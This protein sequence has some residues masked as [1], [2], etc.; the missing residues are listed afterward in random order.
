MKEELL[1][2]IWKYKLFYTSDL[3]TVS[4]KPIYL[5]SVGTHN[6]NSGPD[7]LNAKLRIDDQLWAGNVE[8][9]I[10]ASDWY[11]H[12]HENDEQF[13]ALILHVVWEN[14][15]AVFDKSNN[16]L[17]TLELKNCVSKELLKSY[18]Q[19]FSKSNKFINCERNFNNIDTF[20]IA[21]WKERLY[22][23]RLERKA[24]EI[25]SLLKATEYNWEQVLF[26]LLAKNFG[27]K[28]NS[29]AFFRMSTSVDFN[30][31][32]RE[33]QN[34]K[35]MES[36]L[37]GQLGLLDEDCDVT[38]YQQLRKEYKYQKKKYKLEKQPIP[39]L[40]F[41]LRPTNFPTIRIMQLANLLVQK[42][43]LFTEVMQFN[44]LK[45][46]YKYFE[47]ATSEF[48]KTHYTFETVSKISS[49]KL[50]KSFIDI[51][52]LNSIIPLKYVYLKHKGKFDLD[53]F[54]KLIRQL[55]PEKN[56][57]IENYKKLG[58]SVDNAFESQALLE[59]KKNY[60]TPQKCLQCAIGLNLLRS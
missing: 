16:M 30:I 40:Y 29:E 42:K 54:L 50:T 1:H 18:Q 57:I 43:Y 46:I 25:F 45:A 34:L 33:S 20:I 22:V 2:F 53:D 11:V 32:R 41:R 13:D 8:I 14:D 31:V 56:S 4:G 5:N 9:H 49:K 28:V 10:K 35:R 15:V 59:L 55:K 6:L 26:Q 7:F 12:G 19:L 27:L 51:L 48:W 38:Y 3:K 52:L 47:I 24:T 58:F 39:I 60:C 21:N 17:P 36:L 37:F 23:E 44:S